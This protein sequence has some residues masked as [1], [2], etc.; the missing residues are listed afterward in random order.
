MR[1]FAIIISALALISVAKAENKVGYS[2]TY[3]VTSKQTVAGLTYKPLPTQTAFLGFKHFNVDA[4]ALVGA[5]Q[6]GSPLFGG[7]LAIPVNISDQAFLSLGVGA[8]V[9]QGSK[10]HGFL[11]LGAGWRQ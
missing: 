7:I 3:D 4:L 8:A 2:V 10:P 5:T 1:R 9:A 11:Y 6:S